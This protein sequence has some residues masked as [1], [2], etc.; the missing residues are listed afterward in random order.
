MNTYSM[1]VTRFDG[2]KILIGKM[3]MK[4]LIETAY[5]YFVDQIIEEGEFWIIVDF[6]NRLVKQKKD[7]DGR[8]ELVK[9]LNVKFAKRLDWQN[10]F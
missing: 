3:P 2:Q 1:T 8:R 10:G 9:F 6:C 4:N 7:K 5:K